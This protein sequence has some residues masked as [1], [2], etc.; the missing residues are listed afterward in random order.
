MEDADELTNQHELV[1]LGK[2]VNAVN[3]HVLRVIIL[4]HCGVDGEKGHASFLPLLLDRIAGDKQSRLVALHRPQD[5]KTLLKLHLASD[6]ELQFQH[7]FTKASL[8]A[9]LEFGV[10][11]RVESLAQG[12]HCQGMAAQ[13]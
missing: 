4:E 5:D 3:V 8:V 10:V 1:C 12:D 7:S 9:E 6:D 2:Q 13:F 11:D